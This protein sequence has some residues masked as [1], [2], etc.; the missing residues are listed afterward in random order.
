MI[1]SWE[2]GAWQRGLGFAKGWRLISYSQN[3][4]KPPGGRTAAML[5]DGKLIYIW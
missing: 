4:Q 2:V 5:M 1:N 3:F